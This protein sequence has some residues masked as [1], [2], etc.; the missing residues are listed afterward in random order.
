MARNGIEKQ[1]MTGLCFGIIVYY[2]LIPSLHDIRKH[3]RQD[4]GNM[5]SNERNVLVKKKYPK[6]DEFNDMEF[7]NLDEDKGHHHDISIVADKLKEEITVLCVI[8][9]KT[10]DIPKKSTAIHKTWAKRCTQV[11][12]LAHNV[13][14]SYEL[15]VISITSPEKL[16]FYREKIKTVLSLIMRNYIKQ[17]DW[18]LIATDE[19]YVIMENLR[20]FLSSKN[21]SSP[22]LYG[23]VNPLKDVTFKKPYFPRQFNME[24]MGFVMS[25]GAIER[26]SA[27]DYTK[28]SCGETITG[29]AYTDL[30]MSVVGVTAGS[31]KDSDGRERFNCVPPEH[32]DTMYFPENQEVGSTGKVTVSDYAISFCM[33]NAPKQLGL[34]YHTYHLHAYGVDKLH[35]Y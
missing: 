15:P 30:C 3:S 6:D 25:K 24:N 22:V 4:E 5:R 12:Y 35:M 18:F 21:P 26:V 29:D 1:F 2:F 11:V 33:V 7:K 9:A 27:I 14:S 10:A 20:Y 8:M 34:E 32:L 31:T 13:T 19:T 16:S 17:F 28:I 23:R